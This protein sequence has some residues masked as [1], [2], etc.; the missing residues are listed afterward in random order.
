MVDSDKY[1]SLLPQR[2]D[3]KKHSSLFWSSVYVKERAFNNSITFNTEK[4]FILSLML[5][6]NK[7]G[8][9]SPVTIFTLVHYLRV[10]L[11]AQL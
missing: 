1:S 6:Q 3:K 11:E 4:K 9:F 10:R 7:L 8:C 5:W 2:V